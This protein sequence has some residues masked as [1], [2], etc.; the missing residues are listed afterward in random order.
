MVDKRRRKPT[1]SRP[2][3]PA[4]SF[5]GPARRGSLLDGA[6]ACCAVRAWHRAMSAA[7]RWCCRSR[8]RHP[9]QGELDLFVRAIWRGARR[10]RLRAAVI[11]VTGTNG[12]TTTTAMT[13]ALV[14][15]AGAASRWPATSGRRCSTRWPRHWTRAA[16]CPRSGCWS[17]RASA[18]GASGWHQRRGGA[19]HH[20]DHPTGTG[21]WRPNLRQGT[22]LRQPGDDGAQPRRPAAL[23][24]R[25]A[26]A[27]QGRRVF[28][29]QP[30]FRA[31]LRPARPGTSASSSRTAAA[32]APRR[33]TRRKRGAAP[34]RTEPELHTWRLMPPTHRVR[35]APQ[36][37]QRTGGA[38][39]RR[40]RLPALRRCC[41]ACASMRRR[42]PLRG[43]SS[44]LSA[45]R[46]FD[47]LGHQR[48]RDRRRSTA[49][50]PTGAP[51]SSSS[52]AATARGQDFSAA[53][54]ADGAPRAAVALIGRDAA[55]I[56]RSLAA[57]W[58][59]A[60]L[61][62]PTSRDALAFAQARRATPCAVARLRASL[63]T[64]SGQLR[65]PRRGVFASPKCRR[66][67]QARFEQRRGAAS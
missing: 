59:R 2:A 43:P 39:S 18:D 42:A 37:G 60:A 36:R 67:R 49:W 35:G 47:D 14:A 51:S 30:P 22:H 13:V 41:T 3:T 16:R 6:R 50:A 4:P 56:P 7:S 61:R 34:A 57:A 65:A 26:A 11:A 62:Q 64:C 31:Q 63:D 10:A 12:K 38:A 27:G 54:R 32:G 58:R 48:R 66:S 52:S 5:S 17:C 15:A 23:A 45:G 20:P 1:R 28:G 19:Q 29:P 46:A 33:P 25:D 24:S 9:V 21:R 40:D 55:T 44:P 53:G 8:W